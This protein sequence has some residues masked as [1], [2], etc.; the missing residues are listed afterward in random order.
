MRLFY[1]YNDA[2]IENRFIQNK[3][4]TNEYMDLYINNESDEDLVV[5]DTDPE[6]DSENEIDYDTDSESVFADDENHLD[7]DKED[8]SYYIGMCS[9]ARSCKRHVLS[10]SISAN[11]FMKYPINRVRSYLYSYSIIRPIRENR[12]EIMKTE[13]LEDGWLA[14]VLKTHWI[15]LVQRRWKNIFKQRKEIIRKR[16]SVQAIMLSQITGKFPYGLNRLPG[17]HGMLSELT[18]QKS[19]DIKTD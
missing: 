4:V 7:M 19:S 2:K 11:T 10:N 16:C 13:F 8:N 12:I 1:T 3:N 14:V 6:S 15:R 9:Y 5:Y 18:Y 17:I